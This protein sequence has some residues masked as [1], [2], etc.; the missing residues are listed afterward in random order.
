MQAITVE[1]AHRGDFRK[2]LTRFQIPKLCADCHSDQNLMRPYNLS[3]EQF[4]V[5][6]TSEHGRRLAQGDSRVAVCTDCH[7][8]HDIR[9]GGDPASKVFPRRIPATCGACHGNETLMGQYG[10]D[11][12]P[13]L[14]YLNSLHAVELLQNGNV[15]APDCARCHGVHGSTPPGLGDIDKVC[16]SCHSSAREAYL[17]GAHS[18]VM[19]GAGTPECVSCHGS[20][21]VT[22]ATRGQIAETCQRCHAEDSPQFSAGQ[23]MDV[24]FEGA[25]QEIDRARSLIEEARAIPLYVEDYEARL[26]EAG[27]YLLEAEPAIHAVSL[28]EVE[29]FTGAARSLGEEIQAEIQGEL[30]DLRFRRVGLL[31]FWFY[32]ILTMAIVYRHRRNTLSQA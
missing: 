19:A 3:I 10:K 5:Y 17:E 30:S 9:S 13:Y 18:G 26:Q 11:V 8:V 21:E 24:L 25:S 1:N 15:N 12:T 7:G 31:V 6:Q 16:G 22:A 20:H 29:R 28:R 32:L 2:G 4:A 14:N 27:T 23:R